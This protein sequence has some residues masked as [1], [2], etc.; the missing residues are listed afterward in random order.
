MLLPAGENGHGIK[1]LI[2]KVEAA[3]LT[4]V[5]ALFERSTDQILSTLQEAGSSVQGAQHSVAS[6]AAANG[7][8]PKV[9]LRLLLD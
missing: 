2:Q 8:E 3:P 6:I 1:G 5:A 7:S 9:L 4:Q